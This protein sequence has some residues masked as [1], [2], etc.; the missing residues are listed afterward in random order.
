MPSG[1]FLFGKHV[2]ANLLAHG[3]IA[4]DDKIPRLHKANRWGCMGRLQ[5]ASQCFIINFMTYKMASVSA[6]VDGTID[7]AP[8]VCRKFMHGFFWK[9][10]IGGRFSSSCEAFSARGVERVSFLVSSCSGSKQCT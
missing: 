6:F 4:Y 1:L 2:A 8:V 7:C 5:Q 10:A 9:A 3:L